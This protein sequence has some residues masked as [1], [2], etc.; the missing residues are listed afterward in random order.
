MTRAIIFIFIII[1]TT[2]FLCVN[3]NNNSR[4][5]ITRL[6]NELNKKS[7]R[8]RLVFSFLLF[9]LTFAYYLA[10]EKLDGKLIAVFLLISVVIIKQER[11]GQGKYLRQDSGP[12]ATIKPLSSS[13][14]SVFVVK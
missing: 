9:F 11:C 6:E 2:S 13:N 14:V 5:N 1:I 7:K 8:K 3:N 12:I 10:V 4:N